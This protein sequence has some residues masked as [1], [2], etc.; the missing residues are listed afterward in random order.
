MTLWRSTTD[1]DAGRVRHVLHT[2]G[3]KAA[4]LL[5]MLATR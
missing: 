1:G 5:V 2:G 4:G 3:L